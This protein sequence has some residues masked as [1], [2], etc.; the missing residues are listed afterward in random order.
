MIRLSLA[1][2]TKLKTM[3]LGVVGKGSIGKLLAHSLK[4][5]TNHTPSLLVKPNTFKSLTSNGMIID[6][7][8]NINYYPLN[9][10]NMIQTSEIEIFPIDL[11]TDNPLFDIIIISTKSFQL[12]SVL[13]EL[14]FNKFL[15][16]NPTLIS[17][18]NGITSTSEIPSFINE[19]NIPLLFGTTVHAATSF[20]DDDCLTVRHTGYGATWLG[21]RYPFQNIIFDKQ[22]LC[23]I[24]NAAFPVCTWY[25]D[26]EP[27]LLYKLAINCCANPLT[28]IHQVRNNELIDNHKYRQDMKQICIELWNVFNAYYQDFKH[29]Q[30]KMDKDSLE[31][32]SKICNFEI[33]WK[34][35]NEAVEGAKLNY[36]SMNRD[37]YFNRQTEIDQINGYIVKLGNK[38]NVD[39]TFNKSLVEAIHERE[40]KYL[41]N[42]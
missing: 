38:Y 29:N 27:H 33:L 6:N 11:N 4:Q 37:I 30:M 18:H 9:D 2:L 21:F 10:E 14:E 20:R 42:D 39:V 15:E 23:D 41:F 40:Q 1:E 22:Q 3:R 26:L 34:S 12:I 24:L 28:A 17:F 35:V 8:C 32:W 13:N 5:T 16:N 19:R 36:S 31:T 25:D 7:T